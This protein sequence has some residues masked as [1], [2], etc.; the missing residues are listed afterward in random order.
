MYQLYE[1]PDNK[2]FEHRDYMGSDSEKNVYAE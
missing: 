1:M 2:L